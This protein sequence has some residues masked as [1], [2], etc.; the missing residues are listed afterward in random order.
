MH[1]ANRN[2]TKRCQWPRDDTSVALVLTLV[3]VWTNVV[4]TYIIHSNHERDEEGPR[5]PGGSGV[6]GSASYLRSALSRSC[7]VLEIRGSFANPIQCAPNPARSAARRAA[8]RR[9]CGPYDYPRS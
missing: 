1:A 6:P 7:P 9:D 4:T 8:L 3:Y 5:H 2:G